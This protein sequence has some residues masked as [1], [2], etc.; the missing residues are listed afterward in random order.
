MSDCEHE[1]VLPQAAQEKVIAGRTFHFYAP[2]CQDCGAVLWSKEAE[3]AFSVWKKENKEIFT[4]QFSLKRRVVDNLERMLSSYPSATESQLV[5][6]ILAVFISSV[7]PNQ[8]LSTSIYGLKNDSS[9]ND[10]CAGI[11]KRKMKCRVSPELYEAMETISQLVGNTPSKFV[12]DCV[13]LT[14]AAFEAK[15]HLDIWE[16]AMNRQIDVVLMAS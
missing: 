5:R 14:V 16:S 10:L 9:Y 13:T 3:R 2:A 15:E 7:F 11:E 4:I 6:A 1:R 12:E 8:E